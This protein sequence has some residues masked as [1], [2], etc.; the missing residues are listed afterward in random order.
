MASTL[1]ESGFKD[2]ESPNELGLSPMLQNWHCANFEMVQ[3]FIDKGVPPNQ[4]RWDG[5]FRALHLYA[6]RITYP[7]VY[8]WSDVNNVPNIPLMVSQLHNL[9]SYRD[10][11]RCLCSPAGCSPVTFVIR[12]HD[13]D[14]TFSVWVEKTSLG[15]DNNEA[16]WDMY[17]HDM[18]RVLAFEFL[19]SECPDLYHTCR[20]IGLLGQVESDSYSKWRRDANK[21]SPHQDL[22][23]TGGVSIGPL[24]DNRAGLFPLTKC[25]ELSNQIM[26]MYDEWLVDHHHS[27]PSL[28]W[29]FMKDPMI[30]SK[31][32]SLVDEAST[33]RPRS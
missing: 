30:K 5:K 27:G 28:P 20:L 31:Y 2:I 24:R 26:G 6:Q 7:G 18:V 3:W 29:D 4:R 22:F 8:F 32:E 1:W 33:I 21:W 15:M 16:L 10:D 14:H 13:L 12:S 11:C 17:A 23:I 19:N 9:E 25:E